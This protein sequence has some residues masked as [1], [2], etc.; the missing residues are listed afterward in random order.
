MKRLY[1]RP[2][3]RGYQIGRVLAEWIIRE[4]A[5]IGYSRM[6]LDTISGKMDSAIAMYRGLGF[7]EIDPYYR[8]PVGETLFMELLLKPAAKSNSGSRTRG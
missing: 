2:E 6:R 4:A 1:V 7:A 8:T 5:E 3:F